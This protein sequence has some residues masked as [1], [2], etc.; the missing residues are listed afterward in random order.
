MSKYDDISQDLEELKNAVHMM[1]LGFEAEH[2]Q[3]GLGCMKIIEARLAQ[4]IAD[5]SDK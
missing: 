2:D 4:I 3:T 5:Y 1:S